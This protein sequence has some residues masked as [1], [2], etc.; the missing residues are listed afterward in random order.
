[1][2]RE[3][4][5]KFKL[6]SWP[7]IIGGIMKVKRVNLLMSIYWWNMGDTSTKIWYFIND[8]YLGQMNFRC[9]IE[10]QVSDYRLLG[11]SSLCC[12]SQYKS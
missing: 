3:E 12:F 2:M 5:L 7:P 10:N 8:W 4:S 9:Q 6:E 11:A 1:M